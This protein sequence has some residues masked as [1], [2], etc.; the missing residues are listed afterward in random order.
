MTDIEKLDQKVKESGLRPGYICEKLGI[1]R[2]A[3]S[4]KKKGITP[5][6]AAEIQQL[7]DMLSITSLREKEHIFFRKV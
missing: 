7:C 6:S 5:F 1:S 3:W 4:K 2:S